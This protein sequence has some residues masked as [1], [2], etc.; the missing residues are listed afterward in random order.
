[1]VYETLIVEMPTEEEKK[2]KNMV[3]E[4]IFGPELR[5]TNLG[6]EDFKRQI[7]IENVDKIKNRKIERIRVYIRPFVMG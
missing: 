2:E 3:E 1:M 7:I 4:V 5:A 6:E